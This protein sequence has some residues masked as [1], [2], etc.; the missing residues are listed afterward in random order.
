MNSFYPRIIFK[1]YTNK[2]KKIFITKNLYQNLKSI[3]LEEI[4]E[5]IELN[6]FQKILFFLFIFSG[7]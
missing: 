3:F 5:E 6:P 4:L 2:G 7:V 1:M